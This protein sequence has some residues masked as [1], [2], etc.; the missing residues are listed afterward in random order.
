MGSEDHSK[1]RAGGIRDRKPITRRD[2]LK[3]A[4]AAGLAVGVAAASA[5]FSPPAA[6][7]ATSGGGSGGAGAT[8]R[9]IKVGFVTPLTGPLATFG[10]LDKYCVEQWKEAVKDGVKCGDG[11]THPIEIIVKDSQSDSNRAG[12]GGRGPDHQRRRR[13]HDG[14]L[15]AGHGEPRGRPGRSARRA[16]RLQRLPVAAVL[17]RPHGDPDRC[18]SSG[19]TTPSGASRTSRPCSPACGT[20]SR[21]TSGSA[22]CG[23]TT[24]TATAGPT[25]RPASRRCSRRPATRSSTAAGSRTAPR[26]TR[27]RSPSSRRPDCEIL[28]GVF[29]PPD[30]VN[31]WKQSY[32]QGFKPVAAT[33]GKALLFPAEM[34]AIGRIGYGLT[35]ECWWSP[36]IRS[37]RR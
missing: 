33:V 20:S 21:P 5:A 37:R 2:F 3:V 28:S 25:P 14:R 19:P 30:F 36:G 26:T 34:E 17:L 31:F 8:G 11:Q 6:A 18:P 12:D 23:R 29:I 22:R 35:T 24:P 10:Q 4:G 32:Q 27:R 13:H 15:H 16:L 1:E 7:A 9:A